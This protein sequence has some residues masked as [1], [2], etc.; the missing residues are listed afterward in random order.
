MATVE[1]EVDDPEKVKNSLLEDYAIEI[2]VFP[3]KDKALLRFSF[4]AYN[5]QRD[6]DKLI[7]TLRELL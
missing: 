3:W 6:A 1:I 5:K 2:P 7:N 4:N